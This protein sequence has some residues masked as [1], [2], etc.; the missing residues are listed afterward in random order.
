VRLQLG[1]N[2]GVEKLKNNVAVN[3]KDLFARIADNEKRIAEIDSQLNKVIVENEKKISEITNQITQ[4]QQNL[5]YQEIRSPADG[6]V[7]ELKAYEG[8]VVNNPIGNSAS[9]D[10]LL[11]IVPENNLIANVYI[12]NKDIGFVKTGL[13]VD[14]RI[15]SFPFS[16]FGDVKGE[17]EW[18]GS[19]ALPPDQTYQFYR[20][21]A[22]IKLAKQILTIKQGTANKDVPLQTGMSINANIKLRDRTVMSIFTD[23]FYKQSES[24]KNVR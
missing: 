10:A 20:F 7:F 8:G 23:M 12:T 14:V 17:L 6:T 24:L 15:D 13:P 4:A 22:R 16:E 2:Q 21:P 11:Q 19:D 1:A 18:I 9:S 3:Q 5:K